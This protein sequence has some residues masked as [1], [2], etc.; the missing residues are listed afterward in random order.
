[1][2]ILRHKP[3]YTQHDCDRFNSF[4]KLLDQYL[5]SLLSLVSGIT[6]QLTTNYHFSFTSNPRV[7]ILLLCVLCS[8]PSS[9]P[10]VSGGPE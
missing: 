9:V 7:L 1:M 6:A 4:L 2:N 10:V 5:S 3:Y 8:D